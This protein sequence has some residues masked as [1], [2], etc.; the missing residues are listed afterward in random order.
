MSEYGVAT[1]HDTVRIERTLPGPIER[2][3]AYL[4]DSEKR[5]TW[6]AGGEMELRPGGRVVHVFRNSELTPKDEPPPAKYASVAG[7]HRMEG[8]I[9][10]CE[11]PRLLEYTWP[12]ETSGDSQ[13]RF[14][15]ATKG[16]SVL[17][18]VTHRRLAKRGVMIS[19]AAGW[20]THLGILADRLAGRT[21]GG[22][23]STHMRLEAEYDRRLAAAVLPV[24]LP[25]AGA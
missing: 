25:N 15:L 23:W 16:D 14:E 1:A 6:L 20:H 17:L 21:P 7:G 9:I 24:D 11:P 4:T 12:E 5:A 19:V 22:F 18:V 10:A 3:W 2:V 8:K 13:V